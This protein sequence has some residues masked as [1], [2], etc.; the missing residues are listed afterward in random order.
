MTRSPLFLSGPVLGIET[1]CDET[2]AA[3]VREGCILSNI[4]FSQADHGRYGGVVPELASRDH[5][6]RILPVVDE[7]LQRAGIGIAGLSGIAV[8]AGPGLVGSLLIGLCAAK[9]IAFAHGLPLVGIHHIEGHIFAAFLD[10]RHPSPPF[11][12]L[13]VSGGHTDL[14]SVPQIGLYRILGRTRDDAAGEAFDKVAK[15]LG[16]F[17][18]GASAMGGPLISRLAEDGNP[19]AVRFPRGLI[20]ADHFDFSFSGLKTAVLHHVRAL[21]P[22]SLSRSAP[23]VAASFQAAV[24]DVLVAKTVRAAA[25]CGVQDVLVAGGVAANRVLRERMAKAAQER[26]LSLF[27]P[28]PVL[29]TDNAAMIAAAGSFRMGQ[30]ERSGLDLNAAPRLSLRDVA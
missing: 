24:V 28:P 30:G 8:T 2:S 26:G 10:E 23:D 13:I 5:I 16:L 20:D 14:I 12:A 6:R 15:L 27:I 9:S 22:D 21:D 4:I 1:S 7:A 18:P 29:C 25:F 11:V 3:V 17:R 19:H